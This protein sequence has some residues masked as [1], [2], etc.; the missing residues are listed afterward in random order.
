MLADALNLGDPKKDPSSTLSDWDSEYFEPIHG[1]VLISGDSHASTAEAEHR[2]KKMF[3]LLSTDET[4]HQVKRIVGD[5]R[6]GK[7]KGHE[8]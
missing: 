5:V 8:Q 7:E 6:P 4:M 2:I 1:V 3:G